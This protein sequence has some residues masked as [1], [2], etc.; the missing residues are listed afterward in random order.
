MKDHRTVN[1][2]IQE[3]IAVNVVF[4]DG[5]T[6]CG[7]SLF[8][9]V[10]GTFENF[11]HLQFINPLEHL[12]P[13]V[14]LG[15]VE[16]GFA[17]AFMRSHL[18]ETVYNTLLSRNVNF[19]TT[20]QT[21]VPNH[22]DADVYWKRLQRPDGD[23]VVRELREAIRVFPFMTHDMMV[24][25]QTLDEIN[26]PYRMIEIYRHPVMNVKS[27]FERGWGRRYGSDPRAFTLNV[28]HGGHLIPWYAIGFED[29][30]LGCSEL[31]KCVW[32]VTELLT[33]SVDQQT[34]FGDHRIL[35][36]TF[37]SFVTRTNEE[38]ERIATFLGHRPTPATSIQLSKAN[39][40]RDLD[41]V[42]RTEFSK[43]IRSTVRTDLVEQFDKIV[44]EFE[45]QC[46]G[47][48]T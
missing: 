25:L 44:T 41:F 30:W 24:N 29:V 2:A 4:V 39:C 40:P 26:V 21:G 19:R 23:D 35:T 5:I 12:V 33:R 38:I 47:F 22:P 36:V 45:N 11:E 34:R 32:M 48:V 28:A 16:K 42:A 27:C 31:E 43:E 3:N 20:D 14:A 15:A 9:H 1:Y 17:A 7:K 18:N 8:S 10:I 13:A 6:R 46:F 37:E